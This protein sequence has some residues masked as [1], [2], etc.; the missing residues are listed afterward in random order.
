MRFLFEYVAEHIAVELKGS[1]AVLARPA[2][3]IMKLI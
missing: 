2:D 1:H 3:E